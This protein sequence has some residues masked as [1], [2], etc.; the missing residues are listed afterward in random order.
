M[1]LLHFQSYILIKRNIPWH[2]ASTPV[3]AVIFFGKLIQDQMVMQLLQGKYKQE[4]MLELEVEQV[5]LL[6]EKLD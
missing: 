3:H 2:N 5:L 1:L 6:V 4:E